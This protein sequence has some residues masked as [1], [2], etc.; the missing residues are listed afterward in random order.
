MMYL[1]AMLQTSPG[2]NG[3]FCHRVE[4]WLEKKA[5]ASCHLVRAT[6]LR[7]LCFVL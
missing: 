4:S 6:G 1:Y 2:S 3:E 7:E 5:L